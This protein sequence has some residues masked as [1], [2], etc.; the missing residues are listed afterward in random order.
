MRLYLDSNV[1]IACLRKE[2]DRSFRLL[3]VESE[4]FFSCCK[5]KGIELVV[6][7]HFLGE[8][9]KTIFIKEK[10]VEEF[11]ET[12]SIK[13]VFVE[14]AEKQKSIWVM[15]ETGIHFMDAVHVATA[16]EQHCDAVITFNKK[17]FEKAQELVPCFTPSEFRTNA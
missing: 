15:R 1:L 10:E 11:F 9:E 2:V 14:S 17:D 8:V 4:D 13:T 6:S 12:Y 3:Y 7:R 5:N 16:V